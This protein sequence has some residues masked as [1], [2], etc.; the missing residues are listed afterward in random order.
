MT[1]FR[2]LQAKLAWVPLSLIGAGLLFLFKAHYDMPRT[3]DYERL[4]KQLSEQH[5][6]QVN[7]RIEIEKLI[8]IFDKNYERSYAFE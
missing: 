4:E 1:S 7:Q 6:E 8:V 2:D 3:K 5:L